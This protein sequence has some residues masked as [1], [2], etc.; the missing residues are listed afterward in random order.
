M[1][2]AEA[3]KQEDQEQV[4]APQRVPL[5]PLIEHPSEEGEEKKVVGR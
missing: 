3:S 4:A 5:R 2:N 1:V